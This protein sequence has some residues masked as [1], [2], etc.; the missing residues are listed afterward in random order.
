M[1]KF[2]KKIKQK[3]NG[4]PNQKSPNASLM[5]AEAA[6]MVRDVVKHGCSLRNKL[7]ERAKKFPNPSDVGLFKELCF[8]TT[9]WYFK[10]EAICQQLL[11]KPLPEKHADIRCLL[12][13][14]LY[15]IL[16]L[17]IPH[18]ACVNETVNAVKKLKKPWATKLVNKILRQFIRKQKTLLAN[19]DSE[20]A[21]YAH[22]QWIIDTMKIDWPENWKTILKANNQRP[23]FTLRIN[24]QKSTP[25]EY[26]STLE[27]Q[28]IPAIHPSQFSDAIII[29]KPVG[30]EKLPGFQDGV[31]SVQDLSGQMVAP[32]LDLA[33]N[34][35]ILD[36]CAAPGS[37][38]SH[39]LETQPNINKLV[40]IDIDATRLLRVKEN[41]QRLQLPQEI[42]K[43][44]LDDAAH[45]KQWWDGKPFDRILLDA[46]CSATGVI[47]RHPD[48]KLLR[49]LEDIQKSSQL[50]LLL[51][52]SLWPLLDSKGKLLYTTCSLSRNEND[53]VI[54][55]FLSETPSAK[56]KKLSIEGTI[57]LKH[58]CQMLPSIDKG[59][60]GFYY[61]LLT[62]K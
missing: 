24:Q 43:M 27:E 38:T 53:Q 21:I 50:Q 60:D 48:I 7:K 5:R 28:N 42:I 8:G 55:Q 41:I 59:T 62:K 11:K 18:H 22:P 1:I 34:Q 26:L 45:T 49:T 15:Q 51:L 31:C 3:L 32:L 4:E 47:R 52:K 46:P 44:V 40:A 54:H 14:G 58:G 13:V 35:Y 6:L 9:R 57:A 17:N 2:A 39:I 36:A 16:E 30:T 25:S 37:K 19:L 56:E 61:C 10:L 29:S 23:P 20:Q 33:P 12:Y